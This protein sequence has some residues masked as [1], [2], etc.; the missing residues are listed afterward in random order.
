MMLQV[1]SKKFFKSDKNFI[2]N[3]M[4]NEQQN[5]CDKSIP[6]KLLPEIFKKKYIY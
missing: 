4:R 5:V 3:L 2:E 6:Q 1:I